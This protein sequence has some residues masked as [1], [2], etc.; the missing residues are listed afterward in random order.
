MATKFK[1]DLDV[2]GDI[3]LSGNVTANGDI[4]LGDSNDDSISF[5]ADITSNIVPDTNATY[6]LGS[7][8]KT[9]REVFASK[10]NSISED[11]L[12][13]HSGGSIA[14]YPA[15]NIW[16]KQDTKLIF[17]GTYPDEYE[18]K[19]Q[20]T[21]VTA[22]RNVILPDE[23][24]TLATK[25]YVQNTMTASAAFDFGYIDTNYHTSAT[26]FLLA[27]GSDIDMGTFTAPSSTTIDMGSI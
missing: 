22:D 19:L 15:G 7:S 11:D 27:Q 16:I 17:E 13:I 24:G 3:T 18:I 9:W 25:E 20:A 23:N 12:D 2:T 26:S 4:T 1:Q 14:L 21:T 6:D 5:G 10:I 8:T